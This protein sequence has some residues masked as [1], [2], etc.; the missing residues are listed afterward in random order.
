MTNTQSSA[1][2]EICRQG[3]PLLADEAAERWNKG[4]D[5]QVQRELH[6]ARALEALINQCNWEVKQTGHTA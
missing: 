2:W 5:F 1:L 3:L 4:L 6:L